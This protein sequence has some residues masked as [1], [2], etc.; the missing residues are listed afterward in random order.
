MRFHKSEFAFF[1]FIAVILAAG[2]LTLHAYGVLFSVAGSCRKRAG[3]KMW[4][5]CRSCCS[6][7][8]CF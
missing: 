2:G 4:S 8:A 3:S 7:P 6:P 1:V 5:I